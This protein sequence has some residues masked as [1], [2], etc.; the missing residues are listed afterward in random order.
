MLYMNVTVV[1][2]SQSFKALRKHNYS[3]TAPR[4]QVKFGSVI[5]QCNNNRKTH[6]TYQKHP[7]P[8]NEYPCFKNDIK[9]EQEAQF[10]K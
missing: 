3:V 2:D 7:I 1:H 5:L 4:S 10:E 9:S 8:G 6:M